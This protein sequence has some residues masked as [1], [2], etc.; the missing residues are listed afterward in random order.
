MN[1]IRLSLYTLINYNYY[2]ILQG[3]FGGPLIYRNKIIGINK[4]TFPFTNANFH[5]DKVNIHVDVDY[6]RSFITDTTL[7]NFNLN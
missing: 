4:G 6:Y 3:D 7:S 1:F 5:P 2:F